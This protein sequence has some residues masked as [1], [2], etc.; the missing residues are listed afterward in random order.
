MQIQT[1]MPIKKN[2]LSKLLWAGISV[3]VL[4]IIHHVYGA[5]IYD[6]PFRLHITWFALPV[7]AAMI[8]TYKCYVIRRKTL[9]GRIALWLFLLITLLIAIGT[10][11]FVEGGFNH[12]VK[13][14]LFFS[15][16]ER[17]VLELIYP[18][19]EYELPND[20]WFESTGILQFF[21]GLYGFIQFIKL[22]PYR[23]QISPNGRN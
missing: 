15:G 23:N 12:L 7:L 17:S 21:F 18:S 5:I 10:F 13:N 6:T 20:F 2:L 3:M 1:D 14:I 11:G 19:P 8:L 4:T 9:S 22:W 16:V